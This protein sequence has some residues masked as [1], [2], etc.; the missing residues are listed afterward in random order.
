M[1]YMSTGFA[2]PG[3]FDIFMSNLTVVEVAQTPGFCWQQRQVRPCQ[4][5]QE[6]LRLGP[7]QIVCEVAVCVCAVDFVS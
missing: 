5:I 3:G 7:G 1:H 4:T 2:D 6:V